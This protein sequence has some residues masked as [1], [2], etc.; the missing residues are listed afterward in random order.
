V[1]LGT[2]PGRRFRCSCASHANA[3]ASTCSADPELCRAEHRRGA[4]SRRSMSSSAVLCA[5]PPTRPRRGPAG[6]S[7]RSPARQPR[8]SARQRHQHRPWVTTVTRPDDQA[9]RARRVRGLCSSAVRVR[10]RVRRAAGRA[11]RIR[12]RRRS[13][14]TIAIER[15]AE[16]AARPGIKQKVPGAAVET[17]HIRRCP[18]GRSDC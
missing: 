11:D 8:Q 10:S 2:L 13:N 14:P 7:A 18:A 16:V 5:P 17:D 3:S 1:T 9:R 12:S 15:Q 6:T 4:H